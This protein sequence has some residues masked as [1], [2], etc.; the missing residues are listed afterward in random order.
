MEEVNERL[1][2]G[3]SALIGSLAS[4][5]TLCSLSQLSI[6]FIDD[7][8]LETVKAVQ[9]T[10]NLGEGP[11]FPGNGGWDSDNQ[12]SEEESQ[13]DLQGDSEGETEADF[14][15]GVEIE[16]EPS[17]E[18]M[19]EPPALFQSRLPTFLLSLPSAMIHLP[20]SSLSIQSAALPPKDLVA[21]ASYLPSLRSLSVKNSLVCLSH[22]GVQAI[23]QLQSLEILELSAVRL[24]FQKGVADDCPERM[25]TGLYAK[26]GDLP[27]FDTLKFD[28]DPRDSM[29]Y[30]H[31]AYLIGLC[32]DGAIEVSLGQGSS[33]TADEGNTE[34]YPCY[35]PSPSFGRM[36]RHLTL[37]LVILDSDYT[38]MILGSLT[39][40]SSLNLE[41]QTWPLSLARNDLSLL[42][43]LSS[44][45]SLKLSHQLDDSNPGS[46]DILLAMTSKS[47]HT[48]L[49]SMRQLSTFHYSGPI[50]FDD[51][52]LPFDLSSKTILTDLSLKQTLPSLLN[53]PNL[54]HTLPRSLTGLS[55]SKVTLRPVHLSSFGRHFSFLQ[56]LTLEDF[57]FSYES[58]LALITD[59]SLKANLTLLAIS[60]ILPPALAPPS[61]SCQ[62]P[63]SKPMEG[64]LIA[65]SRLCCRNLG[66]FKKLQLLLL[67]FPPLP[68]A[69]T[70]ECDEL[71]QLLGP[72][73]SRLKGLTLQSGYGASNNTGDDL[74]VDSALGSMVCQCFALR[75]LYISD[76]SIARDRTSCLRQHLPHL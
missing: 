21:L 15:E 34:L 8:D 14:H 49:I 54:P 2:L 73:L 62:M 47:F 40:L 65:L 10:Y 56:S 61:R 27:S 1:I 59:E 22:R 5:S 63:Y 36:I 29:H 75:S 72:C 12:M 67:T 19:G 76:G 6:R 46:D 42:S 24:V 3:Q 53:L 33:P 41:Y 60:S 64:E 35:S 43:P 48:I 25:M 70:R 4:L 28:L 37:S 57:H 16:H 9:A 45:T 30:M 20:L 18:P 38:L 44:V 32:E 31:S 51:P 74:Y 69:S 26:L 50:I 7:I 71:L 17:D 58:L 23:G 11:A 39:N 68:E 13:T 52:S 66:A 55:L